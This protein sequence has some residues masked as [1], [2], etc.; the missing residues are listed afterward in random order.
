M[1]FEGGNEDYDFG[2][3][4][5]YEGNFIDAKEMVGERERERKRVG[6]KERGREGRRWSKPKLMTMW[7]EEIMEEG[8]GQEA[9]F[10]R[11]IEM[12]YEHGWQRAAYVVVG[13]RK[14]ERERS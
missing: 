5:G 10:G 7:N 6:H 14:K 8:C 9:G 11:E 2:G 3:R 12:G 13:R 4:R 1:F